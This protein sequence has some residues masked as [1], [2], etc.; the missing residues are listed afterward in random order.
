MNKIF[1]KLFSEPQT[2]SLNFT[3]ERGKGYIKSNKSIKVGIIEVNEIILSAKRLPTSISID[4]K[5]GI[6]KDLYTE[7]LRLK[8]SIDEKD[9][10]E[11]LLRSEKIQF[12]QAKLYN[13][14]PLI[15][16]HLRK[17]DKL[18]RQSVRLCISYHKGNLK[19]GFFNPIIYESDLSD[20]INNFSIF[21]LS[22][23]FNLEKEPLSLI[24][25]PNFL[26]S[27]FKYT[28]VTQGWRLP[29]ISDNLIMTY[30]INDGK[31]EFDFV[32]LEHLIEV[33]P[34]D[35]FDYELITRN[36]RIIESLEELGEAELLF[37]Q[38]KIDEAEQLLFNLWSKK[39]NLTAL[40]RIALIQVVRNPAHFPLLV[41]YYKEK[42]NSLFI[43]SLQ[44]HL[45]P[46]LEEQLSLWNLILNSSY[47]LEQEEIKL[48]IAKITSKINT[49]KA[50]TYLEE[51]LS[52]YPEKKIIIEELIEHYG[53]LSK[54]EKILELIPII[55]L[56][57]LSPNIKSELLTYAGNIVT[58]YLNDLDIALSLF[59]KA[60]LHN[61]ENIKG[62]FG[63]ARIYYIRNE[64]EKCFNCINYI[65]NSNLS[66]KEG[67]NLLSFQ[68]YKWLSDCCESIENKLFYLQK[69]VEYEEKELEVWEKIV[70]LYIELGD[71]ENAKKNLDKAITIS[72]KLKDKQWTEKLLKL[73]LDV[74]AQKFKNPLIF[75]EYKDQL[76]QLKGLEKFEK[77][78]ET[79]DDDYK[80]QIKEL[81]NLMDKLVERGELPLSRITHSALEWIQ[82]I[83]EPSSYPMLSKDII[84]E[85]EKKLIA[86]INLTP[87][88]ELIITLG[89]YMW[90]YREPII[91]EAVEA[92]IKFK[93]IID[94]IKSILN[95]PPLNFSFTEG[96]NI[97]L[98]LYS[99]FPIGV[100]IESQFLSLSYYE[101]R[102]ALIN[103]LY[104][105]KYGIILFQ[106]LT[107]SAIL[108]ELASFLFSKGVTPKF[109]SLISECI[110][111]LSKNYMTKIKELLEKIVYQTHSTVI[112]DLKKFNL[113]IDLI[114]IL[115]E[116]ELPY[117]LTYLYKIKNNPLPQSPIS[118]KTILKDPYIKQLLKLLI[119]TLNNYG[120]KQLN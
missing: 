113:T 56:L 38:G 81:E 120:K 64:K 2:L 88:I 7:L 107:P 78:K 67:D 110:T 86:E 57:E 28:Y 41:E 50:V 3:F 82:K 92:D 68:C 13:P 36:L 109:E 96:K 51:I 112:E 106:G 115:Q 58:E 95:P 101:I 114:S 39:N 33:E 16:I 11:S 23:I 111:G 102:F 54:K 74:L 8:F 14:Y 108:T 117:S 32:S 65:L 77:S 9:I 47:P 85:I 18:I 22:K 99:I 34:K 71:I 116:G 105:I 21:L 55:E 37:N 104:K 66:K 1:E 98:V 27:I 69:G 31:I 89:E 94:E 24:T 44:A 84:K 42:A 62:W 17:G 40:E 49:E 75:N 46:S 5:E 79:D 52:S 63:L 73:G 90:N 12:I 60:I 97:E 80:D 25:I 6:L 35:K 93:K 53:K 83:T 118:L 15:I 72:K 91:V 29:Y 43:T 119:L 70:N 48:T 30:N 45:E 20:I 19:L 61:R 10:N 87:I 59:K 100:K 4:E 26:T 103:L 76:L